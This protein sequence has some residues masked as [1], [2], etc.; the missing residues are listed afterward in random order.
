MSVSNW[1][2]CNAVHCCWNDPCR[3]HNCTGC[4]IAAGATAFRVGTPHQPATVQ[5]PVIQP[6]QPK[7]SKNHSCH[8]TQQKEAKNSYTHTP[9]QQHS[10]MAAPAIHSSSTCLSAAASLSLSRME[11]CACTVERASNTQRAWSSLQPH[12]CWPPGAR[13]SHKRL[14]CKLWLAAMHSMTGRTSMSCM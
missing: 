9:P 7:P 4:T 13:L 8:A 3:A 2:Q 11:T 14:L 12:C 10:V 1:Q 5:Q 6:F